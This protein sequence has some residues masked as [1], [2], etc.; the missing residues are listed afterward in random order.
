MHECK[1]VRCS[2]QETVGILTHYQTDYFSVEVTFSLCT[3]CSVRVSASKLH[4]GVLTAILHTF[5]TQTTPTH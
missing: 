1:I 3:P 4:I 5:V 2:Q